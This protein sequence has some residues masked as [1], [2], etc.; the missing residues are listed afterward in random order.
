[1]KQLIRKRDTITLLDGREGTVL[2]LVTQMPA[3]VYKVEIS[4]DKHIE[5]LDETKLKLKKQHV[6]NKW[7]DLI[8]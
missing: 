5:Y 4:A 8:R 2:E 7:K 1:M 3:K 6:L